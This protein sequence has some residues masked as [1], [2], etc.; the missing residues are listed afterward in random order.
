MLTVKLQSTRS[1]QFSFLTVFSSF[2]R[3]LQLLLENDIR[4]NELTRIEA[5]LILPSVVGS[6]T[7]KLHFSYSQYDSLSIQQKK[8]DK[9]DRFNNCGCVH[10][11]VQLNALF[12]PI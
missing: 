2:Y 8:F 1:L 6:S 5:A 4:V 3:I 10:S 12:I 7:Y 11:P 9:L